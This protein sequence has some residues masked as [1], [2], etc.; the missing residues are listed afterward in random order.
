MKTF[1]FTIAQ[2]GFSRS[3]IVSA[4]KGKE[5]FGQI[6]GTLSFRLHQ[7]LCLAKGSKLGKGID[8][9]QPFFVSVMCSKDVLLTSLDSVWYGD[10]TSTGLTAKGQQRFGRNLAKAMYEI[11]LDKGFDNSRLVDISEASFTMDDQ[12]KAIRSLMDEC[13]VDVIECI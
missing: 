3:F 12:D 9:R 13:F 4:S 1:K 8:L 7:Q 6:L 2:Q 5:T 10:A 11:L